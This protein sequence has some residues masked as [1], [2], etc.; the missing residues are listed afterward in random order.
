MINDIREMKNRIG[1][2]RKRH[3]S[4]QE[5][6]KN[7]VKTKIY[8]EAKKKIQKV[9]EKKIEKAKRSL[10]FERII[11]PLKISAVASLM[12]P[13][14]L[15][16]NTFKE[17]PVY[18]NVPISLAEEDSN[19]LEQKT[20]ERFVRTV[21]SEIERG[22][23]SAIE[24]LINPNADEEAR[25]QAEELLFGASSSSFEIS[26]VKKIHPTQFKVI[27]LRN[28]QPISFRIAKLPEGMKLLSVE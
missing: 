8:G 28:S 15:I 21:L 14:A 22:G 19:E 27:C 13:L 18:L 16:N 20:A 25:I 6:K 5:K 4:E 3:A 2:A 1:E 23:I 26:A 12:I 24:G 11:F 9:E 7:E 10:K 17:K